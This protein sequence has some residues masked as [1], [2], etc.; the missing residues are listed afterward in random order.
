MTYRRWL[1]CG[2]SLIL[3]GCYFNLDLDFGSLMRTGPLVESVVL[4]EDEDA[5]KIALIEIE[6]LL[7][8][9]RGSSSFGLRLPS[10]VSRTREALDIAAEDDEVA[11]LL[12]RIRSP[13]GTVSASETLHHE[14]LRFKRETGM[15][16][17]AFLQG[18][19]TSGGY[20]VAV[21][22]DEVVSQPTAITGSVGVVM[23][24]LNFSGL[25]QRFG[26]ADQTLT[27]GP[28]KDSGSPL[29]AMRDDEREQLQGVVDGL[30]G[31]FRAVVAEGRP[32]LSTE[33]LDDL[34]DGRIFTGMQA[35]E[36]GLVDSLGHLEDAVAA[37]EER[38]GIT[39]SRL[40]VYHRRSESHESIYNRADVP[41]LQLVD[42]DLFSLGGAPLA[43][44]FYYLW[45][46]ALLHPQ[47][48][49]VSPSTGH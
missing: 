17:V 6:G 32:E 12:L 1:A 27:S 16:V 47:L 49:S 7:S 38:A 13:G 3:S 34:S 11:A 36:F 39:E 24:G 18:M 30:F 20:Y 26:V 19:A 8:D 29:R 48:L 10:I 15:P 46:G 9:S 33:R 41:P 28:F 40:V 42:I 31:R 45:P 2:I 4:G 35:L 25:M 44:G 43:P 21:A 22:S 37:A 14:I 5:A 23:A